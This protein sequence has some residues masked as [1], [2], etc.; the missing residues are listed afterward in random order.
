MAILGID[1][2]IPKFSI[3]GPDF[4]EDIRSWFASLGF[5]YAGVLMSKLNCSELSPRIKETASLEGNIPEQQATLGPE[6]V[7]HFEGP[8][9][10]P[11]SFDDQSIKSEI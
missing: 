11:L 9:S 5:E 7:I 1:H 2:E 6:S 10:T 8:V 4:A 3:E